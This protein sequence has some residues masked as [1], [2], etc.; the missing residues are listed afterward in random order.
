M[1]FGFPTYSNPFLE[2]AWFSG[3]SGYSSTR[4]YDMIPYRVTH[5]DR[6]PRSFKRVI[7]TV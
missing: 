2:V 3:V 4:A 1:H 5:S 6:A 7:W